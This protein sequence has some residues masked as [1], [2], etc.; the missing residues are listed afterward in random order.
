MS[1]SSIKWGKFRGT[2]KSL[3]LLIIF[4]LM[5]IWQAKRSVAFIS[6]ML[7]L[8]HHEKQNVLD[9]SNNIWTGHSIYFLY[10]WLSLYDKKVGCTMQYDYVSKTL[11]TYIIK[12][13]SINLPYSKEFGTL[14]TSSKMTCSDMITCAAKQCF[15][16]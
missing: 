11:E 16:N 1:K 5:L 9:C 7:L 10:H 12:I 8:F 13:P 15:S 2:P 6:L 4:T 14:L 3:S